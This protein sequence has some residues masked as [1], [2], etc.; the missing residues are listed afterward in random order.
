M[1]KEGPNPL[2]PP[3]LTFPEINQVPIRCWVDSESFPVFWPERDSNLRPSASHP[4][5]L[6]T[7]SRRLSRTD[8]RTDKHDVCRTI[9]FNRS[10]NVLKVNLSGKN[11]IWCQTYSK[12]E[13]HI[14]LKLYFNSLHPQ[15]RCSEQW[16]MQHLRISWRNPCIWRLD[17]C[18]IVKS[19]SC[20]WMDHKW[21]Q[22]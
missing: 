9:T 4:S 6:T 3:P 21:K 1:W 20:F 13:D 12:T 16:K 17:F 8:G 5:T 15:H 11:N 18:Q 2:L 7:R 22:F 19:C 10:C 14:E